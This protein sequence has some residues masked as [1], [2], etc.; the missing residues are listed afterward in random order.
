MRFAPRR[1]PRSRHHV[2][3]VE[4]VRTRE[5]ELCDGSGAAKRIRYCSRAFIADRV[6]CGHGGRELPMSLAAL[7]GHRAKLRVC[8]SHAPERSS[9]VN[10]GVSCNA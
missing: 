5:V 3:W 8:A 9:S 7:P 4:N 2:E 1:G 10:A 6:D